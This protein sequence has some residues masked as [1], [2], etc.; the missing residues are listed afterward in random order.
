LKA[1]V[2]FVMVSALTVAVSACGGGS[3]APPATSAP[4]PT[5][6]GTSQTGLTI[7]QLSQS[8]QTVFSGNCAACHGNDGAGGIG[9][10]LWGSTANLK[11]YGTADGLFKFISTAM[12]QSKPGSL[13]QQQYQQLLGYLLMQNKD[14]TAS[15]TFDANNLSQITLK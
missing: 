1:I 15:Q 2:L 8:G 5:T 7:G 6:S 11:K 3:Y 9:P 10:A 13:T 12:P 4:P 14:A